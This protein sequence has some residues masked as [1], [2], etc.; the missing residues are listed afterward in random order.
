MSRGAR[1][2]ICGMP[3]SLTTWTFNVVYKM[4]REQPKTL[5]IE[6]ASAEEATFAGDDSAT[7]VAK[8]HHYSDALRS[9]SSVIIYSYRD[10]RMAAISFRRKFDS[11]YSSAQLDSWVQNGKRWMPVAQMVARY[12]TDA[13]DLAAAVGRIR[14][15]LVG[16][17]LQ[18][19]DL[20][21]AQVLEQVEA[22][23]EESAKESKIRYD[24]TS[25]ILPQHRTYSPEPDRLSPE[26]RAIYDRVS[27]EQADWLRDFGY[28]STES[29]GQDVEYRLSEMLLTRLCAAPV[30][31][32]VGVERGSFTWLALNAGASK[33][34]GFEP[35]PRHMEFLGDAF[36]AES[37]ATFLPVAISNHSGHA[38]FHIATDALGR[39]LDYHHTLSDLGD[40]ATVVRSRKAM[41]V[42]TARLSDLVKR[43]K[44]PAAI[45]F[46]KIDTDGHD[47]AVLEGLGDIRPRIIMA[48]YWD[49]LYETSGVSPYQLS[50]LATW[51]RARGYDTLLVVRRNGRLQWLERNAGY[52][53]P[54]DWGNVFMLRSDVDLSPIDGDLQARAKVLSESNLEYVRD[55]VKDVELKEHEIRRLDSALHSLRQQLSD[56][57][58]A[59]I[60]TGLAAKEAVIRELK[61][62]YDQAQQRLSQREPEIATARQVNADLL[63]KEA[64]IQELKIAR[65]QTQLRL[66]QQATELVSSRQL[67][68]TFEV[69]ADVT[70]AIVRDLK[71]AHAGREAQLEQLRVT[72]EQRAQEATSLRQAVDAFTAS[73][74]AKEARI[75]ELASALDATRDHASQLARVLEQQ[76]TDL[77]AQRSLFA[78]AETRR[79][80]MKDAESRIAQAEDRF[81]QKTSE[82]GDARER[83]VAAEAR[84]ESLGS[85]VQTLEQTVAAATVA[86]ATATNHALLASLEAKEAVIQDLAKAVEAYRG[87][88]RLLNLPLR[89][90]AAMKSAV[91]G[92]K[93]RFRRIVEP[94]LG[95]LHQY[96]PRTMR[97]PGSYRQSVTLSTT[98]KV[99]VITPSFRQASFI[100]RTINSV[101]DQK[102]PN[103]EYFI[104]DGGSTD[105]TVEIVEKYADRIAGW[106]SKPDGGQSQAIN[107]GFART[108]GDIMAWLNSDDVLLPGA[109][110]CIVD[111]F[112]RHPEVD[113]IYGDRLLIDERDREIGR[114]VMPQHDDGVLSWVDYVPQETMFWR[115]SIWDKVGSRIDETFRFAMDWDLLVRFRDAGATFAHIRRFLGAFRVHEAQKTSAVINEVGHLEMTR[116]RERALG[117]VPEPHEISQAVR[118]YLVRHVVRHTMHR[119]RNRLG[120]V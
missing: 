113:V 85:H 79:A 76:T 84:V 97:I 102:Y 6:P 119:I 33:V 18:L 28:E 1:I 48:E 106:E 37:R 12:E 60:A 93:M 13:A 96:P 65:D 112:N 64:V 46:L 81:Q 40:S 52:S 42:E 20:T 98:P 67:L 110:N 115:R 22:R 15:V 111:Y 27:A 75:R 41:E 72:I 8:C 47:L 95:R 80:A 21:D 29:Y 56:A 88:F 59:E 34:Y 10:I 49:H 103:L 92:A 90:A 68:A 66:A 23:F 24:S 9:A 53:S 89:G 77:V 31:V 26:E 78:E 38:T 118:P 108:T 17:G 58:G 83:L 114:W 73:N 86:S 62:A 50:D 39:E 2:L 7:I 51:G 57:A 117:H 99:S 61:A 54:G 69:R 16:A 71:S 11:P 94:R 120:G 116:I 63:A 87:A 30:V 70:E 100:G 36:R 107:L 43:K 101:L 4:L 82:L 44:L 105:G 3:R 5:W 32:D 74:E 25:M 55:L 91:G 35:L 109:I 45:D 19:V 104:Q 14:A